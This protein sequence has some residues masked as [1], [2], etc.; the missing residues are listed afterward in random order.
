ME[1]LL[2][3]SNHAVKGRATLLEVLPGEN[4]LNFLV[5]ISGE[6]IPHTIKIHNEIVKERLLAHHPQG[7]A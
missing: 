5:L 6:L 3:P 7:R 2:T 1:A 4:K